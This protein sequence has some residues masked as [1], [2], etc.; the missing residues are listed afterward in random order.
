M[1]FLEIDGEVIE[2][3]LQPGEKLLL[4]PGHIA[5]MDETVDFDIERVK[6]TKNILFGEGLFFAKVQGPGRV[7]VQTMPLSKLAAALI[8]YL[9][10]Q[11]SDGSFNFEF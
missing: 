11:T 3:N 6:G 9:P 10:T 5:A 1:V 7:W 4:D 8:P 2:H